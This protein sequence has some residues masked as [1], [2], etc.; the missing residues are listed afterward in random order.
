MSWLKVTPDAARA[1]GRGR[2]GATGHN[3]E[4]D[5][6]KPEPHAGF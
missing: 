1:A 5:D 2:S 6:E 4:Q 3:A